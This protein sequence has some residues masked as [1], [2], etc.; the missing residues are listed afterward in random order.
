[1]TRTRYGWFDRR[2]ARRKALA[3]GAATALGVGGLLAVGCGDDDDGGTTSTP[4]SAA[5]TTPSTVPAS[6]KTGGTL[7]IHMPVDPPHL[8]MHR[9][10]AHQL[11]TSRT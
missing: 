5:G 2:F 9:N 8:D 6:P 10:A 11:Y 1:M 7:R 3:G 4:T